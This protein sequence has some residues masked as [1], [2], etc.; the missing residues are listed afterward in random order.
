MERF[1]ER[2]RHVLVFVL[3]GMQ[4][5]LVSR[6]CHRMAAIDHRHPSWPSDSLGGAVFP[7]TDDDLAVGLRPD[8][9]FIL[10]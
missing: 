7:L 6:K 9:L 10:A 2:C 1:H 4:E 8:A 5:P 3:A